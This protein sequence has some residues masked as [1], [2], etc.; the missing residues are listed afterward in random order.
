MNKTKLLQMSFKE[1]EAF[2][3]ENISNIK[4]ESTNKSDVKGA[5]IEKVKSLFDD[6]VETFAPY[7]NNREF[8]LYFNNIYIT[9]NVSTKQT[10]KLVEVSR[11]KKKEILI[12]GKFKFNDMI[13]SFNSPYFEEDLENFKVKLSQNSISGGASISLKHKKDKIID[14]L[15]KDI[16]IKEI[17]AQDKNWE[18]IRKTVVLSAA[19]PNIRKEYFKADF[20]QEKWDMI[21]EKTEVMNKKLIDDEIEKM[22]KVI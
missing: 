22:L 14:M 5:M 8:V 13:I 4:I 9:F 11:L 12:I 10:G 20:N 2:L 19:Q 18:D 6:T 3:N 16:L 15:G 1:I 7:Y 17:Q 21:L